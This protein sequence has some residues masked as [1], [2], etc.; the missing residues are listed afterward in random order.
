VVPLGDDRALG[1]ISIW[2]GFFLQWAI[3]TMTHH[4]SDGEG[5]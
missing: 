3:Q 4:F 1:I 2:V 5:L